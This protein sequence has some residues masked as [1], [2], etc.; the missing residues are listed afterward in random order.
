MECAMSD[1]QHWLWTEKAHIATLTLNRPEAMNSLTAE[2]L[3]ELGD[4]TAHLH[5]RKD[6]WVVIVQGRG[7]IS[8]LAWTST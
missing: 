2:T 4:I 5:A 3:Y 6:L 1:Y 8:P 7:G